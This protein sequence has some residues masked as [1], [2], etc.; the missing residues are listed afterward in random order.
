MSI[1]VSRHPIVQQKVTALRDVNTDNKK[2]R[3][4]LRETTALIAYEVTADLPMAPVTVQSPL[5]PAAGCD[6]GVKVGVIPILRAG[7]GMT[8]PFTDL[9]PN[10]QVWH[11]G[12]YRD[13]VSLLPIE[14][15]N[16]LPSQPTVDICYILDPMLATGNTVNAVINTI[17]TWGV[18]ADRIKLVCILA[19][20]AGIE[21]VRKV[22]PDI[23]IN[24][25]VVDDT[26]NEVGYIVPGLGDAGDRQFGTC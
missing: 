16:K 9:I 26:L 20:Q 15:Y 21:H 25:G 7:L 11:I 23:H 17:K 22:H 18:T 4:L 10:A 2:F 5:A 3:D 12:M 14:Y 8:E 13:K 1:H 19:S 24:V 6:F